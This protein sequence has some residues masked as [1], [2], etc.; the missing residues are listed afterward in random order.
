MKNNK[1]EVKEKEYEPDNTDVFSELIEIKKDILKIKMVMQ[2]IDAESNEIKKDCTQMGLE[3]FIHKKCFAANFRGTDKKIISF[4]LSSETTKEMIDAKF[5][6]LVE[7]L[8]I[9]NKISEIVGE[10]ENE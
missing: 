10:I 9:Y 8:E 2:K 1:T 4:L 5:V 3:L 7:L 6:V